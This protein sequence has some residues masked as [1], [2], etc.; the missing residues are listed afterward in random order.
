M[1][2]KVSDGAFLW[3]DAILRRILCPAPVRHRAVHT[4]REPDSHH[5]E[6]GDDGGLPAKLFLLGRLPY[7]CKYRGIEMP[8]PCSGLGRL[9]DTGGRYRILNPKLR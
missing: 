9:D 1:A 3:C 2:D 8:E 4:G 7:G 5:T 6:R